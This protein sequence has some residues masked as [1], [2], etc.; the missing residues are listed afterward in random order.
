MWSGI[1]A[2]ISDQ[3]D[4]VLSNYS[5][6]RFEVSPFLLL[7]NTTLAVPN[8]PGFTLARV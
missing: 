3:R 5:N 7:T 1:C 8:E 2:T 6:T 4:E